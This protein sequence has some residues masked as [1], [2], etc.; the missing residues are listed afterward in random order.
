M[1]LEVENLWV[2][3]NSLEVLKGVNIKVMAAEVVGLIGPNGS[4]KST[5]FKAVCG[6]L[7]PV[8]GTIRFLGR[9]VERV[10]A[11]AIL[12]Q[13]IGYVP[14]GRRVF[15]SL[16]VD[17]NLDIGGYLLPSGKV[18]TRRKREIYSQFP[19]LE[20]RAKNIAAEL[21]GGQQQILGIARAMMLS[22][23][24]MLFDEPSLGVDPRTLEIVFETMKQLKTEGVSV[25]VI[26]QNIRAVLAIA[27]RIYF[28]KTGNI[29]AEGSPMEIEGKL[30]SL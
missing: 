29:A 22:P 2:G 4:G 27:D 20:G 25:F 1:I 8:I 18:L 24:L 13:G 17:E 26:E 14:Q 23:R 21:S 9:N 3:Y 7:R 19:V 15:T 12:R 16:T 5:L 10:D 28:L 11:E 30:N 6:L